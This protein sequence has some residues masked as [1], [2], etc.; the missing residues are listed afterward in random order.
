MLVEMRV[1]LEVIVRAHDGGIA[2]GVAA[3]QPAF[4]DDRD[5]RNAVVFREIVGGREP[6]AAAADD[7]DVVLGARLG[8]APRA[9]PLLVMRERVA[10][11]GENRVFQRRLLDRK[12]YLS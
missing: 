7:D 1:G 8:T 5:I 10:G 4:F 2:A 12:R 6:V 9:R 3:A 11:E